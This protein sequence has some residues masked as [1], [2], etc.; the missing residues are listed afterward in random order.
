LFSPQ[1]LQRLRLR[2]YFET[3]TRRASAE[4]VLSSKALSAALRRALPVPTKQALRTALS[5][6]QISSPPPPSSA[7]SDTSTTVGGIAP[8][9]QSEGGPTKVELWRETVLNHTARTLT[10]VYG[11]TALACFAH[12]QAA[13]LGHN[14]YLDSLAI[15]QSGKAEADLGGSGH[16]ILEPL[17]AATKADF[18][19][20]SGHF[21]AAGIEQIAAAVRDACAE[22]LAAIPLDRRLAFRDVAGLMGN[23]HRTLVE[24]VSIL[25]Q[26]ALLPPESASPPSEKTGTEDQLPLLINETRD[27]LETSAFQDVFSVLAAE[28]YND[29]LEELQTFFVSKRPQKQPESENTQKN[30]VGG[31]GEGE[32]GEEVALSLVQLVAGH[33]KAVT[34][35]VRTADAA[36]VDVA[37]GDGERRV[38]ELDAESVVDRLFHMR[39]ATMFSFDVFSKQLDLDSPQQ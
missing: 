19:D 9:Q 30:N 31:E 2:S 5:S 20:L 36:N 34:R 7:A 21:C 28:A 1:E 29:A 11:V 32:Q 10:A 3:L 14:V 15:E 25:V 17:T 16:G 12:V 8:T 39:E 35:L 18:M 24:D 38:R 6:S 27:V 23:L 37:D 22:S 33:Q 13:V 26:D 4:A